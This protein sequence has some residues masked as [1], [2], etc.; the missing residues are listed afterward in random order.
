MNMIKSQKANGLFWVIKRK[1][2]KK[3]LD[4]QGKRNTTAVKITQILLNKCSRYFGHFLDSVR[5]FA[6]TKK[7][8]HLS[9]TDSC[10]ISL[11]DFD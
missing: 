2:I 10:T 8:S 6:E 11:N 9:E 7:E 5:L 4:S 3:N 1:K